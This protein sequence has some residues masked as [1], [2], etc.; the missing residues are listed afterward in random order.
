M[1]TSLQDATISYIHDSGNFVSALEAKPGL[2]ISVY[3]SS[4]FSVCV[5]IC[6]YLWICTEN[7]KYIIWPEICCYH[8]NKRVISSNQTVFSGRN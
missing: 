1:I 4:V 6:V 7:T 8:Y 5:Y 2:A 3:T